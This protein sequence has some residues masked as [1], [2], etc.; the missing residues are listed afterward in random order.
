M[1]KIQSKERKLKSVRYNSHSRI[2]IGI[3]FYRFSTTIKG[4]KADYDV[5]QAQKVNNNNY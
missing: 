5:F 3:G 2:N 4:K 1:P